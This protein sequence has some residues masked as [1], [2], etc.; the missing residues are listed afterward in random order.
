MLNMLEK[1]EEWDITSSNDFYFGIDSI[2]NVLG[3]TFGIRVGVY[4]VAV[5]LFWRWTKVMDRRESL[6]RNGGEEEL[7]KYTGED[8]G[9]GEVQTS[10]AQ[11]ECCVCLESMPMGE[12]V[13]ILPCRHVFH[14][15]CINGWFEHGKFTCP[16]CKM[17]LKKHLE[18]R[19]LA[20]EEL[21]A[22]TAPPKKTLR[23]RLWPWGRKI[24]SL[25]D[26]HLVG[27]QAQEQEVGDLELTE[28]S[29]VI[30]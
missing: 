26:D 24:E 7:V 27:Y 3:R 1:Y 16:M 6:E 20:S 22:M 21:D 10:A 17:D 5:F 8:L 29:G 2:S 19:R 11:H 13:R 25:N 15:E 30:V 9:M 28:A 18:E 14:H 23:Q 12:K 4:L